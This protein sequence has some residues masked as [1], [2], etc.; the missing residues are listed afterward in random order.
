MP[1]AYKVEVTDFDDR[2]GGGP[3]SGFMFGFVYFTDDRRVAY[4]SAHGVVKEATGGWGA[5]SDTHV[6]LAKE[7]LDR[8][9]PGWYTG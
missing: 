6:R 8:E 9:A 5:I 7:Y 2:S 4:T 3:D 1:N